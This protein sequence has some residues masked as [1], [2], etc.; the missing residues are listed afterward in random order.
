MSR[1]AGNGGAGNGGPIRAVRIVLGTGGRVSE[2]RGKQRGGVREQ[3]PGAA[4]SCRRHIVR[5]PCLPPAEVFRSRAAPPILRQERW[6]ERLKW[7]KL[8]GGGD[9]ACSSWCQ[10]A[11]IWRG[12][13]CWW[14]AS[15]VQARWTRCRHETSWQLAG[16]MPDTKLYE[17]RLESIG[18]RATF[19]AAELTRWLGASAMAGR[20]RSACWRSAPDWRWRAS[21]RRITVERNGPAHRQGAPECCRSSARM[22]P[23]GLML[24]NFAQS[25]AAILLR[26]KGGRRPACKNGRTATRVHHPA[27]RA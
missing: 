16:A 21:S 7:S 6:R 25:P 17:T 18:G 3:P 13:S 9:G 8:R 14:R 22:A 19:T 1:G 20:L 5:V 2:P 4:R 26:N 24:V 11:C 27:R 23:A 15:S 10:P 12:Q